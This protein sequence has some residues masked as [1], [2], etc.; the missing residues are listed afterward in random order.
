MAQLGRHNFLNPNEY[1]PEHGKSGE[2][3]TDLADNPKYADKLRKMEDLLL[4]QM[5]TNDDPHRL[6]NQPK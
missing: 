4:E 5:E 2:M 1:L 3:Q 6:W